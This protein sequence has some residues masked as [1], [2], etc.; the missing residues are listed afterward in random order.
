[1]AENQGEAS[2]PKG[3]THNFPEVTSAKS[4]DAVAT[5]LKN[6]TTRAMVREE[7]HKQK[8]LIDDNKKIEEVASISSKDKEVGKLIA[9]VMEKVGKDGVVTVDDSNAIGNS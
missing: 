9:E 3:R 2:K 8:E 5:A 1:M 6:P 4:R 7:R